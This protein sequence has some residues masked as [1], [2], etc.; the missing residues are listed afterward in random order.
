MIHKRRTA[1]ERSVKYFTGGLPP[2]PP[3]GVFGI[4]GEWLNRFIFREL[5]STGNYFR[6]A[7]E[8]AHN[9]GDIGSLAKKQ[10]KGKASILFDFLKKSSAFAFGGL[11][12]QTPLVNSKCIEFRINMFMKID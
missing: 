5:G 11:A 3:P 12:P 1:L 9:F 8:Q 4:W 2:P 6:G 7:R 10:K